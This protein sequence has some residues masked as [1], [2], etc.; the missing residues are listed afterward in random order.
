MTDEP[1]CGQGLAQHAALPRLVGA[2][3][4]SVA[5]NLVAHLPGLVSSDPDSRREKRVYEQ[6]AERHREA[7]AMLDALGEE[8]A[9]H[10]DMPMG[11]HDLEALSSRPATE[12]LARMVR[13]ETEL[14]ALVEQQLAEHQAMLG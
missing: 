5:D 6:L 11:A 14:V 13:A 7:A 9:G 8:M 3:L 4:D 1:T 10:Q 2:V 12:A